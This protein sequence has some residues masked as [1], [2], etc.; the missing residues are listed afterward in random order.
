MKLDSNNLVYLYGISGDGYNTFPLVN[1]VQG[2]SGSNELYLATMSSDLTK[3]LFS[4]RFGN[5]SLNG[6]NVIP[7]NGLALDPSGNIYFAGTTNDASFAATAGT[8]TTAV[9]SGTENHTF[10]GKIS[11][12]SIA[13]TTTIS[14]S[15]TASV[16]S[17]TSVTFTATVTGNGSTAPTGTVT[18]LDGTTTLGYRDFNWR[19]RDIYEHYPLYW[20]AQ[21]Q[22]LLRRRLALQ[23]FD[24]HCRERHSDR[25]AGADGHDQRVAHEH[26]RRPE[27]D[28]YLVFHQRD[29]LH[30]ERR[31][32]W[33]RSDQR[34]RNGNSHRDGNTELCACVHGRRRVR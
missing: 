19:Q 28:H 4:T 22:G 5:P 3:L 27:C 11:P 12:L 25:A 21:R 1:P 16:L 9:A 6:G 13:S 8:Y 10:F 24:L 26:H 18:F 30:R 29:G 7:V 31:V 17:G 34:N 15:A 23:H 32:E 20:G 2:Y 33:N 14:S